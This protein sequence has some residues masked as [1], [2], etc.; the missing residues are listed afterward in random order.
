MR[1]RGAITKNGRWEGCGNDGAV[2]RVA[3]QKQASHSF[4]EPLGNLAKQQARFPHFHSPGE[5]YLSQTEQQA[6]KESEDVGG[7][8]VE[9]QNQDSHF[10]TA[11]TA[12]GS[13]EENQIY[14]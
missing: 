1:S 9:I 13:K 5:C 10:P 2:E 11:P 4:H 14:G 3:S 8:K 7:G 6:S 12:C